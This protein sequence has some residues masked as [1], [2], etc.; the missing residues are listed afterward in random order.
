[1]REDQDRSPEFELG[2]HPAYVSRYLSFLK[3]EPVRNTSLAAIRFTTTDPRLS[4]ELAAAHATNFIRMNLETRFELTKEAREFLEKKLAELK[5]KVEKSEE[6]LQHFR[7]RHGVVS[8]EG[9]QNVI[10]DRMVDLNRRLTEARAR[11]IELESLTRSVKDKHFEYLAE[12]I[13]NNLILQLKG[14]LEGMEAEQARLAT[15]FK[16]DHP[17]LLELKQQLTEARRRLRLEIDNVVR[18]SNRTIPRPCREVA[19]QEEA[20]RQQR[21]ALNLKEVEVQYTLSRRTRRQPHHL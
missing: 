1:M 3:V 12:V 13:G 18:G 5:V 11:R 20:A 8:L 14:R 16:P 21:A 17:R 4:E 15:I 6:A 9:N 7:Q 2:V 19:L 10:V